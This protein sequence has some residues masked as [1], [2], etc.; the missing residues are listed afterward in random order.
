MADYT[1]TKGMAD[2]NEKYNQFV[3]DNAITI[4]DWTETGIAYLNGFA[5]NGDVP[6]R[7]KVSKLGKYTSL[8]TISGWIKTTQIN[9]AQSIECIKLP[10]NIVPKDPCYS[11]LE[12]EF[13]WGDLLTE[14]KLDFSTGNIKLT[15]KSGRTNDNTVGN[16]S[17]MRIDML[18]IY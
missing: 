7:Y 4:T 1:M 9:L 11:A 18:F 13:W 17:D 12:R 10:S 2:W 15:N 5:R 8:L 14:G 3:H 6:I 16:K